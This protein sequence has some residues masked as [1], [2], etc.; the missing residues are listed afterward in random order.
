MDMETKK[1]LLVAASLIG[2]PYKTGGAGPDEFN[3]WGLVRYFMRE[4]HGVDMHDIAVAVESDQMKAIFAAAAAG[5]WH[6]TRTVPQG[7]DIALL[8]NMVDGARHVGVVL[9]NS[10]TIGL[11]HA[12]GSPDARPAVGVVWEPLL[13]VLRRYHDI[14][15]WRRG[16]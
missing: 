14:E 3:C 8:R 15:C 4:V 9:V 13:D 11:L 12:E 2:K 16:L 6:R 7:G 10:G 5:G 1:P